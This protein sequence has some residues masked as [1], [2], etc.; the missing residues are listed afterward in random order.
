M[1]VLG[2]LVE[3]GNVS[4]GGGAVGYSKTLVSVCVYVFVYLVLQGQI[5]WLVSLGRGAFDLFRASVP[6]RVELILQ[7]HGE[8]RKLRG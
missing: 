3:T 8:R 6:V 1:Y 2:Q 4:V 7:P 5:S